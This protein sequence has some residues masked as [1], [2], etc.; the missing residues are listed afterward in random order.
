MIGSPLR[1]KAHRLALQQAAFLNPATTRHQ[2][3]RP[4][5]P[6]LPPRSSIRRWHPALAFGAS[7]RDARKKALSEGF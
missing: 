5:F 2:P 3:P 6:A 7:I 4:P 1:R